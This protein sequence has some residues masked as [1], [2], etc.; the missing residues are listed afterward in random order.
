MFQNQRI[1]IAVMERNILIADIAFYIRQSP[2]ICCIYNFRLRLDHIQESPKTGQSFLHHL[3]KL[4]QNLD[5]AD[6][7]A[8]IQC[9]HRQIT[10]RHLSMCDQPS[11]EH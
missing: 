6:E 4:H 10:D 1:I 9:I 3:R 2:R 5:R 11:A 8:D 7:N